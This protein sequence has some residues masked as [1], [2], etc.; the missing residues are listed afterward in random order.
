MKTSAQQTR[1]NI[2]YL[3]H[4]AANALANHEVLEA[5][6]YLRMVQVLMVQLLA[7]GENVTVTSST[8]EVYSR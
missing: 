1:R 3:R 2:E 4:A 8:G 7:R 6:R 5:E